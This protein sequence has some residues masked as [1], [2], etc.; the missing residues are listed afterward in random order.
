MS[1]LTEIT[2]K[3]I[4]ESSVK[5]TGIKVIMGLQHLIAMF[6]ST[7]LV[8]ILTGLDISVALFCAGLGTLIFHLCTKRKVPVFLGSSFA[9]IP[10][11]IAVGEVYGDL[12]YAQG[13]IFVAGLIYVI[14]SF[15]IKKIGTDRLHSFLPAQV[16]GPMIM[17]IGL[18]LIPTALDMAMTNII[19]AVIT[20]GTTLLI[21][22]FGKGFISQ[23][24]ILCGVAVGYVVS[25]MTGLVDTAAISSAQM[26]A[27]PNFTLPKF[28]I[29]AIMMIAPVVL[30]TFMEH[31]GDI[32]TNGQVVGKDFIKDPGLN[33]TLLGDGLATISA[34]LLGGPANTTYGENTGVLAITKNYDPSILRLA[35]VFAIVLSFI[36]KFGMTIRTI[37]SCVMG[38]I[39]LMLFS[40]I[41]LVGVKTIKRERV[42][43]NWKNII[44]MA[45][46]LIIGFGG[47]ILEDYFGIF[48]GIKITDTVTMSGL[49]F[50]AIVGVILNLILNGFGKNNK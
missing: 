36:S 45:V 7:V 29:G 27:V 21:K 2:S 13:G 11:I 25:L 23:I 46:I 50:A 9:F 18:N 40:M 26:V 43:M 6:G 24:A 1:E 41:A 31:I 20:L 37:P 39:S 44:V 32:T 28:S 33:R 10:V 38:G 3:N 42:K 12:R 15:L 49:S 14:M 22:N 19:I 17:V 47:K 35:A 16:V 4:E 5:K 34:S 48:I 30:A 8:P